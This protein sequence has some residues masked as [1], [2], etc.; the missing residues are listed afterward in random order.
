MNTRP[1]PPSGPVSKARPSHGWSALP[2]LLCLL[3]TGLSGCGGE[4]KSAGRKS[5]PMPVRTAVA[6][7]GDFKVFLD[8]IGNVK[9]PASVVIRPQV[10]GT[11]R[12]IHFVEGHDVKAGDLLA[13]I[14]P[15]P[16]EAQLAQAMGQL[17]QAQGQLAQAKGQLAQAKGQLARDRAFL[18]NAKADL[19]RYTEAAEAVT[20]QQLDTAKA[21][22]TQYAGTVAADEGTIGAY[23]GTVAA[24]E[25]AIAADQAAVEGAKV[26]LAY[27]RISAPFD[28]RAGIRTV[29]EGSLVAANDPAGIVTISRMSPI[30]AFFYIPENDL[31]ALQKAVAAAPALD[32][33]AY[34]SDRKHLL[35]TG[36]L[37]ALDNQLDPATGTVKLRANFANEAMELFPNQSV[38]VRMLI[39]THAGATLVPA[40]AVQIADEKRFVYVVRKEGGDAPSFVAERRAV[41]VGKTDETQAE[42]L[43]GLAPGDTVATD[44]LDRLTTG[45]KVIPG[46]GKQEDKAAGKTAPR[47]ENSPEK[48]KKAAP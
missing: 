1:T 37:A 45:S 22:V 4:A 26:Q 48:G 47:D 2:L 15:R 12:K 20:R 17:A 28:G 36:A 31:A 3:P 24:G 30:S 44:G 8:A 46:E 38:S 41:K 5:P 9:S 39:E 16:Y 43:E 18:E 32:V 10:S 40:E 25:G 14:D 13:E 19:A 23:E 11:L 33:L 21:A 34:D 7:K 27:C 42:I 35:S 6:K 29:D